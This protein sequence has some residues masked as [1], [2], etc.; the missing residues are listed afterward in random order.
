MRGIRMS[1]PDLRIVAERIIHEALRAA[2]PEAAVERA[3]A[4]IVRAHG[5]TTGSGRLFVVAVGKASMGMAGAALSVLGPRVHGGIVVQPSGYERRTAL[6][7]RIIVLESSHPTPDERGIDAA[8]R[9]QALIAGM[10]EED[11]CLFLLSGGG[12][13]LLPLPLPPVTLEE[14]RLTTTLLLSSG[15][16]IR[17][18]NTVRKHLSAIKGGRLALPCRGTIHTLAISDVAGDDPGSI[19]SGPTVADTTTF[20][21]ASGVLARYGI[22]DSVPRSVRRLL[23]EG[24]SGAAI[25]TPKSL[26]ARHTFSL[27]ASN[28]IAV[29][30]AAGEAGQS[31]FPPLVLTTFLTGEAREAGRLLAGVAREVRTN[32]RPATAPLCLLLGGE[33]TVTIRGSGRGGRNQEL[34]LGAAA[35]LEGVP[36]MEGILLASFATDGKEGNTTAAGAFADAGTVMRGRQNGMDPRLSLSNNDSNMFLAAA[37]DLIITGPTGTNVNDVAFLL[38]APVA[39]RTARPGS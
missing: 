1:H 18:I 10:A 7:P 5:L 23:D 26:P 32:G 35:E 2:R 13:S 14:K 34:A 29:E 31:G 21:D 8:R 33:T 36:G 16:D 4:E 19:A 9:V 17:E 22:L 20:A 12:S 27:I 15:A 25:E 38:I 24:I 11:T 37:G 39:E 3:L 6:D 28:R 30:A